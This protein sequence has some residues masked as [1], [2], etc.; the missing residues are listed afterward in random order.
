MEIWLLFGRPTSFILM[1]RLA[2]VEPI[3]FSSLITMVSG[4]LPTLL[5]CEEEPTVRRFKIKNNSIFPTIKN[6]DDRACFY[7][8]I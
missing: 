5:T 8:R 2:I 3:R 1:E 4:R 7:Q 6:Q